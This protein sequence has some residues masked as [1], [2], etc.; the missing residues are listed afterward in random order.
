MGNFSPASVS[1]NSFIR[2]KKDGLRRFDQGYAVDR[3][4]SAEVLKEHRV[5]R[6]MVIKPLLISNMVPMSILDGDAVC[7]HLR[8]PV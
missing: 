6:W 4:R 3:S 7:A 5:A 1:T 8:Y 2:V